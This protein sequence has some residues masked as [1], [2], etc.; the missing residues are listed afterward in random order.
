MW[1]GSSGARLR[2]VISTAR[3]FF[4]RIRGLDPVRVDYV[5][6]AVVLIGFEVN[7]LTAADE[8]ARWVGAVL[9][10]SLALAVATRRRWTL[11][12]LTL[13]CVAFAVGKLLAR[14]KQGG[15]KPFAVVG[16]LLL[17][18]GAGA[19]SG[20]TSRVV[21][22][23]ARDSDRR[24][25]FVQGERAGWSVRPR[26]VRVAALSLCVYRVVQEALTNTLKHAGPTRAEVN[27]RWGDDAL[28]LEV[29]DDG[30]RLPEPAAGSSGHG[31]AG[32]YE[33]A[34]LHGGTVHAG[35][36]PGG[37]FTVQAS[38]PL[39]AGSAS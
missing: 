6:A 2:G 4:E 16:M 22:V 24:G 5:V 3:H 20:R 23:W 19:F 31:I 1:T 27:V 29:T 26:R 17:F 33:R 7:A 14:L 21:G 30:G 8:R 12:A 38:I 37:G 13:V 9:G 34:A 11:Q 28:E 10:L 15:G 35:P 32:M 25:D 18:Y 36:A 39:H